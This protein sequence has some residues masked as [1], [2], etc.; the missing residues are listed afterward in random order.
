MKIQELEEGLKPKPTADVDVAENIPGIPVSRKKIISWKPIASIAGALVLIVLLILGGIG[1]WSNLFSPESEQTFQPIIEDTPSPT[2]TSVPLTPTP[3]FG[4]G[5]TMT[6]K[7]G[8][9][10]LYVPAGEFTMGSEGGQDDEKPPHKVYLDAF[11][12]DETEVTIR[13]YSLCVEAGS[14]SEPS[15]EKSSSRASYYGN[16][17]FDNYP[18][19]YV[20]WIN[21][22][23]YCSWVERRLPTKAEWEKAAR[24]ENAFIYP[25]GND[26]PNED[27]ANYE[28]GIRDTTEVGSYPAGASPYGV[29]DMAGNEAEMVSGWYVA[30]PGNTDNNSNYG[31]NWRVLRGGSWLDQDFG[32]RSS[33]RVWTFPGAASG[34]FFGFRCAVDA[35]P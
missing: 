34:G 22:N 19:I 20:D 1:I 23:E 18:V 3:E 12:I 24:G 32:I 33:I 30:Y 4:I 14:C 9:T 8:M 11:W 27:L 21:V 28:I 2:D 17:V 15:N 25:W 13:M 10:L 35:T 6:G 29:L 26:Q 31:E 16:S 7:D 5:S